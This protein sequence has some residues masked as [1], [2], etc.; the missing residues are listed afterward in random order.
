MKRRDFVAGAGAALSLFP[1]D[2]RGLEREGAARTPEGGRW[3]KTGEKLSVIG[4]GGI[5]VTNGRPSRRP[6]RR[7]AVEA[8]VNYFDVAPT[9]GNAQERLGPALKPYRG[10][11]VPRL[12]DDRA[13]RGGRAARDGG[14][15]RLLQT[16]HFDLYQL[17][18]ITTMEDVEKAFAKGGAMEAGDRSEEAGTGALRRL[19]RAQRRSGSRRARPLRL[20]L[21]ALPARLPDVAAG[22]VRPLGPCTSARTPTSAASS[23]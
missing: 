4:F 3:G 19:L 17:H 18:A 7:A 9:Y 6:T 20:R 2:L 23:P 12:Q 5:V 8:G 10:E 1:A 11:V 16:D 14:S 22:G 13:R 21:G 15:L